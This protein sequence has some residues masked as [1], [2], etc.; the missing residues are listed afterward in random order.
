M[1]TINQ[2]KLAAKFNITPQY[3]NMILLGKR[4]A[5]NP[6]LVRRVK[7]AYGKALVSEGRRF[8]RD[9]KQINV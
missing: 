7:L 6:Q 5:K 3:F 1:D 9:A 2:K 8:I 4:G